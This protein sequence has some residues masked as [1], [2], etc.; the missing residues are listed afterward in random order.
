VTLALYTDV[1][2]LGH[3][4]YFDRHRARVGIARTNSCGTFA[5]ML[6]G[7]G[8]QYAADPGLVSAGAARDPEHVLLGLMC[9]GCAMLRLLGAL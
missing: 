6:G 7:A 3:I 5:G 4:V 1:A 8:S 9:A 2:L